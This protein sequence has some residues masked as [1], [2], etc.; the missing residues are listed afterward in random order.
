M[1][2]MKKVKIGLCSTSRIGNFLEPACVNT[3]IMRKLV[4]GLILSTFTSAAFAQTPTPAKTPAQTP[5]AKPAA[6][7]TAQTGFNGRWEG[8][9][10]RIGSDGTPQTTPVFFELTQ[11]GTALAG[12]GGPP[13]GGWPV[14]KGTVAAGK[15]T[16]QL[17]Q[18]NG[19]LFKFTLTVVKGRL[20]GDMVGE[21]DGKVV[22]QAKVDAGRPAK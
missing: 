4:V 17:Q 10:S 5:A 8:S 18:P 13:S 16:F 14:E 11:K 6:A 20:T 19:P 22:G 21:R 1:K 7:A 12:T 2:G 3:R 15:A 9:F